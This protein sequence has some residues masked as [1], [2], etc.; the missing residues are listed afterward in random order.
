MGKKASNP[1]PMEVRVNGLNDG[2]GQNQPPKVIKPPASV[3]QPPPPKK[4]QSG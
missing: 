1:P 2:R 3:T 4:N